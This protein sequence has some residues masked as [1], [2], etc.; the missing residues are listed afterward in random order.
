MTCATA[1]GMNAWMP[2]T[3]VPWPWTYEAGMVPTDC[4]GDGTPGSKGI[5]PCALDA[6]APPSP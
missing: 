3:S 4:V 5:T 6:A 1:T 2:L